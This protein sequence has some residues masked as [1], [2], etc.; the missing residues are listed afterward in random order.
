M[1]ITMVTEAGGTVFYFPRNNAELLERVLIT[2][3]RSIPE[4][5]HPDILKL[6][7]HIRVTHDKGEEH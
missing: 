3:L 1:K 4:E 2:I 6:F 5:E 7:D